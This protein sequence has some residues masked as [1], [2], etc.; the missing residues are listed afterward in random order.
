MTSP[1]V[2]RLVHCPTPADR[3]AV[4]AL[5]SDLPGRARPDDK[6]FDKP[7]ELRAFA[8][9]VT[10]HKAGQFEWSQFQTALVESIKRWEGTH[11][12][13]DASWSYYEHWVNAF[14]DVLNQIGVLE[15]TALNDRTDE[16]LATPANKNHHQPHPDP[17]AVHPAVRS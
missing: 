6:G 15:P 16:V 8:L 13:D 4:E 5:I 9:A 2:D 14:E 12:L 3:A 7:W 11:E 17:V 10:A 1:S